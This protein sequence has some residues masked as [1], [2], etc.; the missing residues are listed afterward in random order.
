MTR[1]ELKNTLIDMAKE[2]PARVSFLWQGMEE[3]ECWAAYEPEKVMV[4]ASTIKTMLMMALL[5][6][7][8]K[9]E[10]SLDQKINVT[11]E[12]IL[13]DSK[14]FEQGPGMYKLDE[15]LRFMITKSDNSCTNIIINMLTMEGANAYF[16]SIG[17][18]ETK[19]ERLMLDFDAIKE[20][21]NNYTSARDQFAVY[22]M[23]Y[24]HK[25]LTPEMCELALSILMD[26]R[27]YDLFYR[28]L[29]YNFKLAHKSGGLDCLSHDS[30]IFYLP[31]NEFYLGIFVSDG[32]NDKFCEMLIGAM[33]RKIWDY[34]EENK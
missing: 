16:A 26:N 32:P 33:T 24:H 23:M 34:L 20:G 10:F 18:T 13:S 1:E 31:G 5:D 30:G 4:S 11:E 15:I 27:D 29:P 7:V 6:R 8:L 9:G 28:Y 2:A 22:E 12:M 21:R 14:F 17:L 3:K 19:L 25:V